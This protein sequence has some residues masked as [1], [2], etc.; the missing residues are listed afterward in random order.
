MKKLVALVMILLYGLSSTGA[1]LQMHYCCGKLKSVELGT[2]PVKDCGSKQKM[3]SRP[4]C[5]TKQV[6]AKSKDQQQ[7]VYTVTFGQQAP[8][9]FQHYFASVTP[10]VPQMATNTQ[11]ADHSPPPLPNSLFIL[12]CVFRI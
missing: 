6:S 4:C 10:A 3:G 8:A 11:P 7:D 2:R 12:Y 9:D 5:E 1:T